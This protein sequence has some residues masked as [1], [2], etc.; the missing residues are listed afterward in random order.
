MHSSWAKLR[1]AFLAPSLR[2][3]QQRQKQILPGPQKALK[4]MQ[5]RPDSRKA[6][7]GST[8]SLSPTAL[9]YRKFVKSLKQSFSSRSA[10]RQALGESSLPV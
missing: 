3:Q 2:L 4:P 5:L 6:S 7:D 9:R 1:K 8:E 10:R